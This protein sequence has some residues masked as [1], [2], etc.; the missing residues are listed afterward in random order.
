MYMYVS[1]LIIMYVVLIAASFEN[2][3]E[4]GREKAKDLKIALGG[5]V[6]DNEDSVEIG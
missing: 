3:V 5:L 1:L 4:A 6:R 2:R